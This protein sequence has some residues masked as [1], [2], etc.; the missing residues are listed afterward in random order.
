MLIL[1]KG[2]GEMNSR[3]DRYTEPD[4]KK[5]RREVGFNPSE[6]A[7][8]HEELAP[9]TGWVLPKH[10]C[11]GCD[12]KDV[13]PRLGMDGTER[14]NPGI[15]QVDE[16]KPEIGL[17]PGDVIWMWICHDCADAENWGSANLQGP[18]EQRLFFH[19]KQ[20]KRLERAYEWIKSAISRGERPL[21]SRGY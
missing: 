1:P 9:F 15:W 10:F 11:P 3:L 2:F 7:V 6:N 19:D 8:Q 13:L 4:K 21:K 14:L 20:E 16:P 12:R 18:M 17:V 5:R